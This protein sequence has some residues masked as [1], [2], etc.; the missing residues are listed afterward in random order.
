VADGWCEKC[1]K[2]IPAYALAPATD[3]RREEPSWART[4]FSESRRESSSGP[5]HCDLCDTA[6]PD[7]HIRCVRVYGQSLTLGGGVKGRWLDVRCRCCENC[8]GKGR[9]LGRILRVVALMY[10]L[11]IPVGIALGCGL[12]MLIQLMGSRL[13][14]AAGGAIGAAVC[15]FGTIFVLAPLYVSR[16]YRNAI[17]AIFN[18]SRTDSTLRQVLGI[19]RWGFWGRLTFYPEP[20]RGRSTFVAWLL[21]QPHADQTVDMAE[22]LKAARR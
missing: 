13:P 4:D 10:L 6:Q 1:G 8:Y 15:F 9:R 2:K 21:G 22:V 5:G 19:K 20:T 18:G 11:A 12:A 16:S 17:Q 7:T 3:V 14:V